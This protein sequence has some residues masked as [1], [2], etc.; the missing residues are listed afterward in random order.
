MNK[1]LSYTLLIVLSFLLFGSKVSAKQYNYYVD[2]S[3]IGIDPY[4]ASYTSEDDDVCIPADAFVVGTRLYSRIQYLTP[5]NLVVAYGTITDANFFDVYNKADDGEWYTQFNNTAYDVPYYDDENSNEET[6]CITHVDNVKLDDAYCPS[7]RPDLKATFKAYNTD[8]GDVTIIVNFKEGLTVNPPEVPTKAGYKFVCWTN[9][10]DEEENID[11]RTCYTFVGATQANLTF[12]AK[13]EKIIYTVNY[14]LNG[15][16]GD[17]I[18]PSYCDADLILIS[19]ETANE[20]CKFKAMTATRNGYDFIGWSLTKENNEQYFSVGED[21]INGLDDNYNVTL[22]AVWKPATYSINYSLN[23]G[24]ANNET[25]YTY[26]PNGTTITLNKPVKDDYN[27]TGWTVNTNNATVEN[28][29]LTITG[30]GN[31]RLTANFEVKTLTFVYLN[32]II[33]TCSYLDDTCVVEFTDE[34]EEGYS[35]KADLGV[36]YCLKE[37][38]APDGYLINNSPVPVCK[39]FAADTTDLTISMNNTRAKYRYKKVDEK[40]Q[41]MAG[42]KICI[43]NYVKT[44]VTKE[45]NE[46]YICATTGAEGYLTENVVSDYYAGNGYYYYEDSSDSDGS[47]MYYIQEEA[48]TGYYNPIFSTSDDTQDFTLSM[49]RFTP[50]VTS[51]GNLGMEGTLGT[52]DLVIKII[53]KKSI[54]ISKVDLGSGVEVPGAQM[55]LYDAGFKDEAS[56]EALGKDLDKALYVEVDSWES[57]DSAHIFVGLIPGNTYILSETVPPKGDAG[58]TTDIVFTV[59]EDGNVEIK[60]EQKEVSSPNPYYLV[61]GNQINVPNTGISLLNLFAIGGLMVFIGYEVIKIYRK[62]TI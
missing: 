41:P 45:T 21:I 36:S 12:E 6:I 52:N 43:Y 27:F 31:V 59:D 33:Q 22:Y 37:I 5:M 24:V 34:P 8:D 48:L 17:P 10:A 20:N 13:Y 54:S 2:C 26:N 19:L 35:F 18:S 1:K 46:P 32:E 49:T 44:L 29:T 55:H 11:N 14:D 40:G 53:N 3:A 28:D 15:A 56:A 61:V 7:A 62:R 58:L 25:S 51:I 42:V 47:S 23:N 16:E 38:I 50:N 57:G 30:Y 4:E 9:A 60:S 39:T